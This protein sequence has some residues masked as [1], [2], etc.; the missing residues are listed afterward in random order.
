MSCP[1]VAA[2]VLGI[3][4]TQPDKVHLREVDDPLWPQVLPLLAE[5]KKAFTLL[6]KDF[7]A[8]ASQA[9][10]AVNTEAG[11]NDVSSSSVIMMNVVIIKLSAL[12]C[13]NIVLVKFAINM[14]NHSTNIT[15]TT[16]ASNGLCAGNV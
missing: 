3:A 14:R 1:V 15:T 9:A 11:L 12:V 5:L 16:T 8:L 13:I 4:I 10:A 7:D 6:A 2:V